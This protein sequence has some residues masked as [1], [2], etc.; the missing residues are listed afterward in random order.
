M[1]GFIY[2]TSY[3]EIFIAN[4]NISTLTNSHEGNISDCRLRLFFFI[5]K[6]DIIAKLS[7]KFNFQI[8][9][10]TLKF[11]SSRIEI[12]YFVFYF[13]LAFL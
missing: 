5:F 12:G 3:V 4:S 10:N 8:R 7:I 11:S 13:L 9:Q 6:V 2:F 1:Y